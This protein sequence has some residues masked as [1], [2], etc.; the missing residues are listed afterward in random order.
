MNSAGQKSDPQP[1]YVGPDGRPAHARG[2]VIVRRMRTQRHDGEVTG[3]EPTAQVASGLH[4]REKE[5]AGWCRAR[6]WQR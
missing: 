1:R 3:G 2:T 4:H 6:S 5:R